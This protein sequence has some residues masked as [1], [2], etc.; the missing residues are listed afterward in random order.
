[1]LGVPYIVY[2]SE[3]CWLWKQEDDDYLVEVCYYGYSVGGVVGVEQS[4]FQ[5]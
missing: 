2:T 3:V 5:K 1:M 4:Y